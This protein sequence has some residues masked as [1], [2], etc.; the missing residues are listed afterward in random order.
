LREGVAAPVPV[1]APPSVAAPE[2]AS[3][4]ESAE[5]E[6]SEAGAAQIVTG[7]AM[8][9]IPLSQQIAPAAGRGGSSQAGALAVLL[10]VL[11]AGW[12]LF[13]SASPRSRV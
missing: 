4:A 8:E 13:G 12:F 7:Y 6:A 5:A 11:G 2:A 10:L 3:A 9:R 1:L